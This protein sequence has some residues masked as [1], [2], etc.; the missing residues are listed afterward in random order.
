MTRVLHVLPGLAVGGTEMALLR[1][2]GST[3]GIEHRVITLTSH[4]DLK[5]DLEKLGV[6]V[7]SLMMSRNPLTWF[8]VLKLR[9]FVGKFVPDIVQSWLY[10]ADLA[11]VFIGAGDVGVGQNMR[12]IWNIRQSETRLINR[13]LHIYLMQRV[14][15]LLSKMIPDQ[16]VYCGEVAQVAHQRIGYSKSKATVIPNGIDVDKYRSDE[17]AGAAV[18]K[19]LGIADDVFVFGLVGRYDPL[20]NQQ[21]LL[22]AFSAVAARRESVVLI[23]AGRGIDNAN[24]DLVEFIQQ[25]NLNGKV[26]LLG[27]RSDVP[28]ILAALD[29]HVLASISEGWPNVLAEAMATKVYCISTPV[30]DAPTIL[31]GCGVVLSDYRAG[32]LAA[33]MFDA[34]D[35][36]KELRNSFGSRARKRVKAEFSLGQ[37]SHSYQELYAGAKS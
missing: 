14:A 25:H 4:D 12:R 18:R 8:R 37:F 28:R 32:S 7:D 6:R 24:I 29:C 22:N 19:E 20:K 21:L 13:Q 3:S 10:A 27:P 35:M 5:P 33:A 1:L 2:V 9:K 26:Q 17:V 15:A 34:V 30:G 11:L 16:I 31:D 23:L 36:K